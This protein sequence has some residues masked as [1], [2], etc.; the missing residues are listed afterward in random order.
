MV[1]AG[2]FQSGA[3][4]NEGEWHSARR[5]RG[6]RVAPMVWIGVKV[7]K[8]LHCSSGR[9]PQWVAW[10]ALWRH[11]LKLFESRQWL[12]E[13]TLS[14]SDSGFHKI[15][16]GHCVTGV[17]WQTANIGWDAWWWIYSGADHVLLCFELLCFDK[18]QWASDQVV[19]HLGCNT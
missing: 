7:E 13:I 6:F 16:Q 5:L 9:C 12:T 15:A 19:S 10:I 18:G 3:K 4:L 1:C 11:Y 2:L 8:W 14:S 17:V